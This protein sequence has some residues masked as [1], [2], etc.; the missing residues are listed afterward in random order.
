MKIVICYVAVA[1]GPKTEEY[2][3]RFVGSLMACHPGVDFDLVVACNGGP[4]PTE[5]ALMFS[6]FNP[7]FFPRKNEDSWDIGAYQDVA[8]KFDCDAIC[9]CGE[10]AYAHKP[11]WLL[12]MVNAWAQYGPGM[13]GFFSSFLVRPHLNTTCFLTSPQ[14]LN[15]WPKVTTHKQRYDFE[16]GKHSFWMHLA[17]FKKPTKFVTWTSSYD[18]P[19]WRY[20]NDILW[21]GNQS[22]LLLFCNHVDRFF[23][24]DPKTKSQW[25]YAADHGRGPQ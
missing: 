25:S 5:N 15:G 9:C 17:Q 14:F 20:E 4:L 16:H 11:N 13:Y 10:S 1:N 2:S 12:P 3:S 24:A 21:R 6:P 23:A 19:Q 22:S 7:K 18:P 8:R